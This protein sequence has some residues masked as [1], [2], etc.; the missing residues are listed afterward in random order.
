MTSI[1][2]NIVHVL[3]DSHDIHVMTGPGNASDGTETNRK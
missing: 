2:G 1:D 3:A